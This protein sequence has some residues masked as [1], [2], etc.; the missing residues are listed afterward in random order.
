[1]A[2]LGTKYFTRGKVMIGVRAEGATRPLIPFNPKVD[3]VAFLEL[4][5]R[6]AG[7]KPA[8]A[9]ALLRDLEHYFLD[10]P[11]LGWTTLGAFVDLA[12]CNEIRVLEPL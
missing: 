7:L 3:T 5:K 9:E 6:C 2:K 1:M 11:A 4:T 12:E 8:Q 10:K